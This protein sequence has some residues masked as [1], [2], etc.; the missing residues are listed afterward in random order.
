MI[1]PSEMT[2]ILF[3]FKLNR[4]EMHICQMKQQDLLDTEI[5]HASLQSHVHG[6]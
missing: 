3:T 1:Q 5:P 6:H 4:V 2:F